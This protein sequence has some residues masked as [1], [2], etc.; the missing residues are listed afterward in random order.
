MLKQIY[1][2]FA[3]KIV[4]WIGTV[5]WH[6]TRTLT[7]YDKDIIK[8]KLTDN[9][10]IILTRHDGYLSSYAIAFSHFL[11]TGKV[12]YYAHSLMNVEDTVKNDDDYRF[13]EATRIGVHYSGFDQ[14][15]DDQTS[16]VVLLKPKNMALNRWTEVLDKARSYVGKEYDT[17]YDLANDNKLSCVE[18]IRQALRG[19]PDYDINFAEFEKMIRKSKNLDPQMF[20]ECSDFEIEC[21]IRH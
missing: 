17:L 13:I 14:A 5:K 7:T 8:Q 19:E 2:Y 21:E 12:G 16:S 10:F 20:Y 18:L 3:D 9:Y 6:T 1:N 11:L 15:I 4:T